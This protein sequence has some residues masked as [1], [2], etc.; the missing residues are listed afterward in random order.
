VADTILRPDSHDQVVDAVRG[1]LAENRPLEVIGAGTKRAFGRYGAPETKLDVAGLSGITLYEPD[2]LVLT[3]KAG[4]PLGIIAAELALNRQQL[5]F[6]P[7]DLSALLAGGPPAIDNLGATVAGVIACNLAGPRRIKAGAAR[8]YVLGF[9]AVSGRGETFKSGGRVMKNV[10]GFDLS[11]LVTGSFGTLA[12]MT[13]VTIKVLPAPEKT[14]TVL[15]RGCTD[16]AAVKAMRDAL[17]SE[18][19]VA[20]AAHLPVEAAKDSQ[21]NYVSS[22]GAAVT[23]VRIEGPE[24]SVEHRCRALRKLLQDYGEIEE[25]HSANSGIFWREARDV[26]CFIYGPLGASEQIWRLSVPPAAGPAVVAEI[27][28]SIDARVY[29]DWGGGL[30]WLSIKPMP[31]AGHA[32]IRAAL[33]PHGG[34]ATLV[35]ANADV[36]ARVSVFQP[37]PP[38]LMALT[39]R[40]KEAF[41]PNGILNPGRMYEGV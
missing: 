1:A 11:K 39:K 33:A 40:V 9:A 37:Q 26:Q 27:R 19:E 20:A 21:V 16:E 24:P 4:T 22:A 25:L 18:H 17:S 3:A 13:E 8:D 36:R 10:T 31:D 28:K 23:A 12:V 35:R 32:A 29:Y 7:P 14:R 2:E 6:E 34:H 30:V 15:V 38:A 41:D 5:A